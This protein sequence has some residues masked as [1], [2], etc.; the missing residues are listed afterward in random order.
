MIDPAC[1]I[2]FELEAPARDLVRR[3]PRPPGER[4]PGVRQSLA[5]LAQGIVTFACVAE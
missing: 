3:L 1:A 2:V 4:L 5:C